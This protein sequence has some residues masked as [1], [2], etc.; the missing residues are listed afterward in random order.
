MTA[1]ATSDPHL[2]AVIMAGGSGTRFWPVSRHRLPKQLCRLVGDDTMIQA[3]VARLAPLV[4]PQRILVITREDLVAE[5]AAQLPALPR[6]QILGEPIGRDTAPCVA[7]AA[8]IVE[9]LDPEGVMLVLPADHVIR[10]V[11]ALQESF[12]LGAELARQGGLVTYGIAPRYAAT[13]YGYIRQGEPVAGLREDAGAA[14][15]YAV[16]AFVEK[17]KLA[18]AEEYL[19]DGGYLWNSGMFT[20]K[21][22]T[23]LEEL[24]RHAPSL[25]ETLAPAMADWGT[26]AFAARLAAVYPSLTRISIDYAL[27]E[28]AS[29]VRVVR[30]EFSWDDVGSWDSICDHLPAEAGGLIRQGPVVA[31]D[32]AES[33]LFAAGRAAIAA[34]GVRNMIVVSTDDAVLVCPRGDSQNVKRLVEQLPQQ[35]RQDLL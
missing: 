1:A 22:E 24:R 31:E 30:G 6:A 21:A 26:S 13:G 5:T 3:T 32:C 20:W 27:M 25:V 8:L 33:L 15:A 19:R 23:V 10:P 35:G 11:T 29:A 12:R 2:W 34:V 16:R 7:L 18:A 14:R 9:R 4:D 28:K 17:P